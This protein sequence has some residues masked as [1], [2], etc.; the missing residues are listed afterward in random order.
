MTALD[1]PAF[2]ALC[3]FSVLLVLKMAAIGVVTVLRRHAAKVVVNPEDVPNHPGS[4]AEAYE[5]PETLRAKR[6]HLNDLENILPFLILATIYTLA[7][8][9]SLGAW[10]YFGVYF[11][12]RTLHSVFYLRALQPWRT[13]SFF[14]CQLTQLGLMVQILM[15]A[16][17]R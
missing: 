4:H 17:G 8:G 6:A 13:A 9:S 1:L 12:A 3:L 16:F 2:P 10:S 11:V 14:L 7:G 15:K 5:A